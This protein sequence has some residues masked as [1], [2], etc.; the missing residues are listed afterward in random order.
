VYI[1]HQNCSGRE[2]TILSLRRLERGG[3]IMDL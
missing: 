2:G 3:D 1:L